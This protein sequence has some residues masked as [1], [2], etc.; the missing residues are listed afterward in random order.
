M[1]VANV[2][3]IRAQID[4]DVARDTDCEDDEWEYI[5]RNRQDTSHRSLQQQ[6]M[7]L[8]VPSANI[9]DVLPGDFCANIRACD[10]PGDEDRDHY[11]LYQASM[12]GV[13]QGI[14]AERLIRVQKPSGAQHFSYVDDRG[15][16]CKPQL[17]AKTAVTYMPEV[18]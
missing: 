6:R 3:L 12:L 11:C 13:C 4:E 10:V 17:H 18:S 2:S 5:V 9:V 15:R 16:R 8:Y 14:L 1:S 7:K